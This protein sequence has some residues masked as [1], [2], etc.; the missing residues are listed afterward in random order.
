HGP[1]RPRELRL[2]HFFPCLPRRQ[3]V[4]RLV[5]GG[6]SVPGFLRPH[7]QRQRVEE[8]LRRRTRAPRRRALPY[9]PALPQDEF[10]YRALQPDHPGGI[11]E[12]AQASSLLGPQRLQCG[13]LQISPL[14]QHEAGAPCLPEQVVSGAVSAILGSTDFAGGVQ[15]RVGG[16]TGL[17]FPPAGVTMLAM[18]QCEKCSRSSQMGGTRKLLR[19]HYN[20]VNKS[21]KYANIQWAATPDGRQR[22]CTN[23]IKTLAKKP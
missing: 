14:V 1:L 19:G 13:A 6:V 21:R 11:L 8:G 18:R 20:P 17:P 23:C 15:K 3:R 7:G 22:L 4:L 5:P 9:L 12:L 10:A 16:Y 2:G